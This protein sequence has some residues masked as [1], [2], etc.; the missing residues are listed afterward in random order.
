VKRYWLGYKRLSDQL[1]SVCKVCLFVQSRVRF[2]HSNNTPMIKLKLPATLLMNLCGDLIE[3]EKL[4]QI[5]D[6]VR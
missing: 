5:A 3:V 1:H 4:P 2:I 6:L